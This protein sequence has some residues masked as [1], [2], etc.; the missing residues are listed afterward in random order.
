MVGRTLMKP[1]LTQTVCLPDSDSDGTP[2]YQDS[3]S[4][5]D[6]LSDGEELTLGT[7][8]TDS[9]T[10]GDGRDDAVEVSE[11]TN[12]LVAEGD[13]SDVSDPS[14]PTDSTDPS[15][16]SDPATSTDSS[17]PTIAMKAVTVGALG[18]ATGVMV[19]AR[20]FRTT[21]SSVFQLRLPIGSAHFV[22]HLGT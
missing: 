6:G 17:E 3:D 16:P 4:D 22:S 12:P 2:D 9:D 8:P 21:A 1:K 5:D 14:D 7:N 15:D 13:V 20:H 11:G 18:R 10:D 19:V